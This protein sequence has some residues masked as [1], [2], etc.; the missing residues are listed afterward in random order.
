M[1]NLKNYP[2][3]YI[4]VVPAYFYSNDKDFSG[5]L[6]DVVR[7]FISGS[8]TSNSKKMVASISPK[9]PMLPNIKSLNL[10]SEALSPFIAILIASHISGTST[11][12]KT[13]RKNIIHTHEK[14]LEQVLVTGLVSKVEDRDKR[15]L[16]ETFSLLLDILDY[17]NVAITSDQK[18]SPSLVIVNN[19]LSESRDTIATQRELSRIIINME[20][21]LLLSLIR[22]KTGQHHIVHRAVD[23]FAMNI[24]QWYDT[25]NAS[26][27]SALSVFNKHEDDD[28]KSIIY[29][30]KEGSDSM[31]ADHPKDEKKAL[32]WGNMSILSHALSNVDS[33]YEIS[34][35]ALGMVNAAEVEAEISPHQKQA[36]TNYIEK[37]ATI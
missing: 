31:L 25:C 36:L 32:F 28:I 30:L 27:I 14:E 26:C 1:N 15:L 22:A 24:Y 37:Y 7:D 11:D 20:A 35:M 17:I 3:T 6:Y 29:P 23:H 10:T 13:L 2:Y 4:P 19:I 33:N 9:C 16:S 21:R 8:W 12:I 18:L 34:G 5:A